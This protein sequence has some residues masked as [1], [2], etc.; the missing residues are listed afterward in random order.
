MDVLITLCRV[1]VSNDIENLR[2]I[3]DAGQI[4]VVHHCSQTIYIKEGFLLDRRD[5]YRDRCH[6]E[7]NN[8]TM[9]E[10]DIRKRQKCNN[11]D[12]VV[13]KERI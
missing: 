1:V 8:E 11:L 12:V 9:K 13:E 2:K 7:R 6:F 4:I 5:L 3:E 10:N